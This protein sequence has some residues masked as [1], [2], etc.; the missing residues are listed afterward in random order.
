MDD[1]PILGVRP[2]ETLTRGKVDARWPI[3]WTAV[4]E[5]LESLP[6]PELARRTAAF[7]RLEAAGVVRYSPLAAYVCATRLT[8]PAIELRTRIVQALAEALSPDEQGQQAP[9]NVRSTL[10]NYLA[11]MRT[12]PIFALLQVVDF[13]KTAEPWVARLLSFCSFAGGHLADI[14]SNRQAPLAIRKQAAFYIGRIGYLD[15]LPALERMAA[16]LESRFN[17]GGLMRPED[18]TSL[19]PL[20]QDALSVLRA[21]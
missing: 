10:T 17:A 4:W 14:L 16:R 7:D 8:E 21:P 6:S 3:D 13:D 5:A 2:P 18:E 15:A 9:E 1:D 12:R 19:L 20:I 11:A